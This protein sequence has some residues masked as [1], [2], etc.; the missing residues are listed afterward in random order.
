MNNPE[1]ENERQAREML[2]SALMPGERLQAYTSGAIAVVYFSKTYHI[3]LTM[4]RLILVP[5]KRDKKRD[6]S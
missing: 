4:D 2:E 1:K 3:G 5:Y 6:A